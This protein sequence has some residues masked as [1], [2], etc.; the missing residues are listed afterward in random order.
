MSLMTE[1]LDHRSATDRRRSVRNLLD[2]TD[3]AL[4][5]GAR[6]GATVWKTGFD[7]LD[8]TLDGGLR[9]GE[10]VLLGG[11]EGS[12][13]TTLA[14]Q[15]IRNAVA[16]GRT[17]VIFSFEHEAQTIVQRLL[18]LEAAGAAEASDQP[19][20]TAADVHD[21]RTVFEAEDPHRAGLAE[22]LGRLAYGRA[23]LS[24]MD[25]YAE[26]L[27]IHAS[28]SHT[29]MEVIA[30]TVS[31]LTEQN[32]EPPIVLVDYLQK[33]PRPGVQEDEDTRVTIVTENL[34]NLAME[35][36][37]PVVAISAADRESLGSG[38]RMRT[39]DLRGS[40]ALAYEADVVLILSSKENIVSREHLVYDLGAI[41]IYRRW[42][43]I[44]IEKNRHGTASIELE[45]QKN[46]EH[47]RFH[48]AV[49]VVSERL[50]EERV[51]TT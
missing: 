39:R 8:S 20:S 34:K 10:L 43:V 41:K 19:V 22:A 51:F 12:G 28:N 33:V 2:E 11:S 50:I 42:S 3:E 17:G 30:D 44:T 48:P 36:G 16:S 5:K 35:M 38:H 47:G 45:A 40:S 7:L 6:A 31:M 1:T 14:V 4:R 21:F 29:T 25:G 13:K 23:A 9:S 37:C 46:F 32:G 49:R 27:H 26:R 15:M 18:G 24:M